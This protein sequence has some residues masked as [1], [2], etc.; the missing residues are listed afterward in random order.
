MRIHHIGY[1]VADI[2]AARA[3]FAALGYEIG[4]LTRDEGRNVLIAFC[5]S[6][7]QLVELIAPAGDGPSPVD[8]VLGKNGPAPYH[9]CYAVP[10]IREAVKRMRAAGWIVVDR[11]SPAPA[12]EGRDVAF[13]Y[14]RAVGLAEL[15]EQP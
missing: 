12:I 7:D 13:L 15:V 8:S 10:D 3:A 9:I 2:D 5:R 14:H 11:P 4:E 1:A 6:G